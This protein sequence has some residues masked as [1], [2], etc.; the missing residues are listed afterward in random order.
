MNLSMRCIGF[1]VPLS[2]EVPGSG[3]GGARTLRVNV[4]T[5]NRGWIMYGKLSA[6][7][8]RILAPRL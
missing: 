6:G 7:M 4:A 2:E 5:Q 3:G 8:Q 1:P